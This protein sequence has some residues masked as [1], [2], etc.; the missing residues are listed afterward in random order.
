MPGRRRAMRRVLAAIAAALALAPGLAAA[1][2]VIRATGMR[3]E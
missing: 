2:R 3:L 1:H